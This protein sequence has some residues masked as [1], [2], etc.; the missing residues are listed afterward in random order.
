MFVAVGWFGMRYKMCRAGFVV[1]EYVRNV[2]QKGE[3]PAG[4]W[5]YIRVKCGWARDATAY[6]YMRE[7]IALVQSADGGVDHAKL[8]ASSF[9]NRVL[10]A[11]ERFAA[12][13]DDPNRQADMDSRGFV[14]GAHIRQDDVVEAW[15]LINSLY[16]RDSPDFKAT[17]D[18][19]GA[20]DVRPILRSAKL[21]FFSAWY[22]YFENAYAVAGSEEAVKLVQNR[23]IAEAEAEAAKDS[24][25]KPQQRAGELFLQAVPSQAEPGEAAEAI[26]KVDAELRL[27]AGRNGWA[28]RNSH[29]ARGLGG[30]LKAPTGLQRTS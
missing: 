28:M 16:D 3:V 30:T 17:R 29:Y 19:D 27:E 1:E 12:W 18:L 20:R 24:T 15:T 13:R 5:D 11:T 10:D 2:A 8:A 23:V 21:V 4:W 9:A 6:A 25:I 22:R 14:T 26:R 7:L